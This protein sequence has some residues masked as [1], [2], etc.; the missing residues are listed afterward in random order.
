[1]RAD[2]R[3]FALITV[4]WLITALA[5]LVALDV[6]AVRLG[7]QISTNRIVM[8]RGRWA[9]E[10][11]L[12]IVQARWAQHRLSDT[13]SIDLGRG[14]R[15]SW[16][17]EDPTVRLNVNTADAELLRTAGWND[18]L[19]LAVLEKRKREPFQDVNQL[20]Q[21]P[22]YDSALVGHATVLGP[23]SI[24]L[25]VAPGPVLLA[26]P[27]MTAEAVERVLY[28]R[29]VGRPIT[30]L[31]ELAGQLSPTSRE[32]FLNR[33]GDLARLATFAPPELVVRLEG[34]VV[35]FAPRATIEVFAVPLP[36]RLAIV[37]RRM[38]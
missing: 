25:S 38:W 7:N 30:N 28:R 27:G 2:R 12:A 37:G 9:S 36:E 21:L 32:L 4:L 17:T 35:G 1:M 23:G 24:N 34:W 33:Y 16:S 15:C 22:G 5:T 13:A 20:A 31:D 8:S 11:C 6:S 29:A 3:G 19:V 26:L 14:T 10:A 18:A